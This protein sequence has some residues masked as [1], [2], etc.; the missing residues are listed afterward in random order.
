MTMF[1]TTE[2]R[3][4]TNRLLQSI[5]KRRGSLPD[6]AKNVDVPVPGSR[7]IV[8]LSGGVDSAV[9]AALLLARGVNVVGVFLKLVDTSVCAASEQDA[10]RVADTLGL[11]LHVVDA[12][13][14]FEAQVLVPFAED[15]A[16]GRTPSP[17][18][19]C[20]PL[21]KFSL[22][23]QAADLL[24]VDAMATGHYARRAMGFWHEGQLQIC[25]N[26][27]SENALEP[28]LLRPTEGAQPAAEN[29]KEDDVSPLL[30]LQS[31]KGDHPID[32]LPP[33]NSLHKTFP[34]LLPAACPERDQSYFL[35]GLQANQLSNVFFPL[36]EARKEDVRAWAEAIGL[37]VSRKSDSQDICF[38][39]G[40]Y[41]HY[42]EFL[43]KFAKNH[44]EKDW[45]R[46]L[47]PGPIIG[48]GGETL[49]M[50]SGTSHYTIGQRRGLGVASAT[51]LYV[52]RMEDQKI[53]VGSHEQLK[54][55]S[56]YLQ[57]VQWQ[58]LG[59]QLGA[60][61]G[62]LEVQVQYRS[63]M[64]PIPA[65][66]RYHGNQA[67]VIFADPQYAVAPGQAMVLR[68][69]SGALFGGGWIAKTSAPPD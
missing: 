18:C 23:L 6:F 1:K 27:S 16:A 59:Q 55:T 35:W 22:L 33:T 34:V 69:S 50:H 21:V 13:E 17:C 24:E 57:G 25:S 47:Q 44:S 54:T 10:R 60:Q 30:Q 51:P 39:Q 65:L 53:F 9:T 3:T 52:L 32:S 67:E 31:E 11:P 7:C 29:S 64:R 49:G 19:L 15:Y 66:C 5:K 62:E 43:E 46:S 36:G 37:P 14:L 38:L 63:T 68:H 2:N 58:P 45:G 56:A 26:P 4:T 28:S 61:S 42:A 8:G 48:S 41:Q 12:R 40:T 20:N